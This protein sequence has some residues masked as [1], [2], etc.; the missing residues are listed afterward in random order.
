MEYSSVQLDLDTLL[1]TAHPGITAVT[2]AGTSSDVQLEE[3]I[4]ALLRRK[5]N[6][7]DVT[8]IQ[9]VFESNKQQSE[10]HFRRTVLITGTDVGEF[11][12]Q[13]EVHALCRDELP[14]IGINSLF[15]Q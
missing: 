14:V 9:T 4:N 15:S 13:Y 10:A 2:T 6:G 1:H 5:H 8:L 12:T 7:T 3:P 11:P